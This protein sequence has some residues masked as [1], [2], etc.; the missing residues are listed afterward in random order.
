MT[1]VILTGRFGEIVG[2]SFKLNCAS[3][4]EVFAAI[5]ANTGKLRRYLL[6]NKR[7]KFSIFVD[8]KAVGSDFVSNTE[9]KD[10]TVTILPI[11]MG[12]LGVTI[13]TAIGLGTA[14]GLTATGF[15]VAAVINIA[16]S[17]GL[18]LLM[19]AILKPDDPNIRNTSSFVFGQAENVASQGGPVPVNYGR[20]R[21]G[22]KILSVNKFS[23]DREKFED[24]NFYSLTRDNST[25]NP[26]EITYDES[27]GPASSSG[28]K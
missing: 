14:T 27:G 28:P 11:L 9:V 23:V 16:L 22:S 3:L 8:G 19:Q 5:E 21:V 26:N 2:K 25:I 6:L 10:K 17:I 13:A 4:R 1:D 18:S 7:R 12:G 15:V 24:P 20:L